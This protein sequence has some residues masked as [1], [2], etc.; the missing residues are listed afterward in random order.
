MLRASGFSRFV[1]VF[2]VAAGGG[3]G[4]ACLNLPQF[5]AVTTCSED[6]DCAGQQRCFI[7]VCAD[8]C[9]AENPCADQ[10]CVVDVGGA[11]CAALVD[12]RAVGE[13]CGRG[14]ECASGAC[15]SGSCVSRCTLDS[16]CGAGEVCVVD[17]AERVCLPATNTLG[18]GEVCVDA[19]DCVTG[20]CARGFGEED[21]TCR[22]ACGTA[23]PCG[24]DDVCLPLGAGAGA[25]VPLR[26][27]GARCNDSSLCRAGSCVSDG[28]VAVCAAPCGDDP[29][30]RCAAGFACVVDESDRDV[31]MPLRNPPR[32][33]GEVCRDARD[34]A[35]ALCV[36]FVTE[37]AD[38]GRLCASPCPVDGCA[39][40]Q[41]CWQ[42]DVAVCGPAP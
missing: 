16:G 2:L 22:I 26:E 34:C 40:G 30:S 7:D 42:G 14:I 38:L 17:G 8:P 9:D 21:A 39:T 32:G 24:V 33:D 15:S 20:T 25:C 41:V 37:T 6:T 10:A 23:H 13:V 27:D 35:S 36:R 5:T 11:R 12:D 1:V 4:P 19:R 31:C 18:V 3:A 28:F 29:T